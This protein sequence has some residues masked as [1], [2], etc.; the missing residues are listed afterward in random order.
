[1]HNIKEKAEADLPDL[2]L[3]AEKALALGES[4]K[5]PVSYSEDK[6]FD[7]VALCFL[8]KQME[9]ARSIKVLVHRGL[10]RDAQLVARAM[11]ETLASLS[12]IAQQPVERAFQWRGFACVEDWRLMQQQ[13]DA[14]ETVDPTPE[15]TIDAFLTKHGKVFSKKKPRK[16]GHAGNNLSVDD[17]YYLNWRGSTSIHAIFEET[18]RESLYQEIYGPFSDWIHAGPKGMADAIH[19]DNETVKWI[20]A[21]PSTNA[22]VL[23]SS[24]QCLVETSL[25]I[26]QHFAMSFGDKIRGLRSEYI[27]RFVP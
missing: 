22:A 19:R 7:F 23:A 9:H 4:M 10:G 11:H 18:D 5:T 14:G 15:Q 26:D 25:I 17:P 13:R 8:S 2:L 1:M 6:D 27:A 24:F 20:L 21:Q 3:F 12:W 16:P